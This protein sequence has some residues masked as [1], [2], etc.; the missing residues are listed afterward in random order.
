MSTIE[1][2]GSLS[3]FQQSYSELPYEEVK[4]MYDSTLGAYRKHLA[5]QVG[6]T[7]EDLH[8]RG[9][10]VVNAILK[11]AGVEEV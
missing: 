11:E 3:D 8:D 4:S 7:V 10:S 5:E 6:L 1:T 9:F 2:P